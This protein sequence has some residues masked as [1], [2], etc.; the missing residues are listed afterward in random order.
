MPLDRKS[1]SETIKPPLKA[2]SRPL[3]M[4]DVSPDHITIADDRHLGSPGF[5]VIAVDSSAN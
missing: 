1:A 5:V 3:S 4:Y 2:S